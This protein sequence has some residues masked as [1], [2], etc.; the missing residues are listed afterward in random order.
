MRGSFQCQAN[1]R[2]LPAFWRGP[3]GGGIRL[4]PGLPNERHG[5]PQ[6]LC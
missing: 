4:K 2:L 5:D 1:N 3:M 6:R